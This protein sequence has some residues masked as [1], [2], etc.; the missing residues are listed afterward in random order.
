VQDHDGIFAEE[1]EILFMA[2]EALEELQGEVHGVCRGAT[3]PHHPPPPPPFFP[4]SLVLF[5]YACVFA[6]NSRRGDC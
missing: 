3:H 6:F 2:T 5:S 1:Q 4:H